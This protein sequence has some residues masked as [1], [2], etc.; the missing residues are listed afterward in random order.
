MIKAVLFDVDGVLINSFEAN[1]GFF[2]NLM[3]KTGYAP[4]TREE[5]Q[6]IFPMNLPDAIRALTQSTSEEEIKKICEIGRSRSTGYD[7]GLLTMPPEAETTIKALGKQYLL[8]IVTSRENA[9]EAPP[10]AKLKNKFQVTISYKDTVNH[11]PHPE[12]LL[13]AAQKLG[14][15]PAECVYIGDAM[16]DIEAGRAAGM[17]I[18]IYSTNKLDQADAW[19]TSFTELPMLLSSLAV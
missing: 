1:L 5:F 3:R 8:G 10:L 6:R 2:Q 12:P 9:Y 18:I 11:K 14:V 16:S 7:I 15:T 17:K 13:L 19:T 4:P